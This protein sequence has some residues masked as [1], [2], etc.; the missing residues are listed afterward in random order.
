MGV[1]AKIISAFAERT[2][3]RLEK[4]SKKPGKIRKQLS[5]NSLPK[6]HQLNLVV[7]MVLEK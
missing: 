6:Q 3:R 4:E 1:K 7:I 5:T 2:R